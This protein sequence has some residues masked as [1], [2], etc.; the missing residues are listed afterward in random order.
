MAK[1]PRG[2]VAVIDLGS[3][4]GRVV[5]YSVRADGHL[6]ILASSRASLR[7]VRELDDDAA[8]EP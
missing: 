5:V 1:P 2:P 4:S 3:N 8:P 7:L 6:H